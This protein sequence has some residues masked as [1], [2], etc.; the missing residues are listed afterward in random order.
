MGGVRADASA[1]WL[2]VLEQRELF[3]LHAPGAQMRKAREFSSRFLEGEIEWE[4]DI[5]KRS[6]LKL[7]CMDKSGVFL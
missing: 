7:I 4:R 3:G 2:S 6:R 5:K 1:G